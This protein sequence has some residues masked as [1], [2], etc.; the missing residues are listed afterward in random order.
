MKKI[1]ILYVI[2]KGNWGGA[3]RYVHDLATHL[4]ATHYEVKVTYGSGTELA[5][6]LHQ[7]GL[8]TVAIPALGRDIN[9]GADWRV[10]WSLR[11]LFKQEK[12]A[13]VHLNSA[14]IGGLGALA[15][16]LTGVPK[17]IFTA[18]GWAFHEPRP[19]WQRKLISW[20]SWLTIILCHEVIV[21]SRSEYDAVALWPG[22]KK[23]ITQIYNGVEETKILP[24]TEAREQLA[25]KLK[26]N[27][28][29]DTILLG[30]I[31]ELHPNKGLG[32]AVAAM[33]QLRLPQPQAKLIIIGGGEDKAKLERDLLTRGLSQQILL[34]GPL[35]NAAQ[36]LAA[37]DVFCLPSL[38]EGLPYVLLEAG[39]A[40]LP[41]VATK[42]GGVPEIIIDQ[43]TGLVVPPGNSAALAQALNEVL[44]NSAKRQNLGTALKQQ[45]EQH[46]SLPR[47][48]EAT[49]ALY[50]K[51]ITSFSSASR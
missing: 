19:W 17:I 47:M 16:R 9:L 39:L 37:F 13:V 11:Q 29:A 48:L 25:A 38:K 31:A 1:K 28:S 27:L 7:A 33:E 3:Q 50:A 32:Y 14:K 41:V 24:R 46:F 6:K 26:I 22:V 34:T 49:T 18:H 45:V 35:V 5:A 21:I 40:G 10:F 51:P 36:Y 43:H 42:V 30:T 2:T 4:P 23:K 12:P 15:A 8:A 44:T 20:L